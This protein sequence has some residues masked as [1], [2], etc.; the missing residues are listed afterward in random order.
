MDIQMTH[1]CLCMHMYVLRVYVCY[2]FHAKKSMEIQLFLYV[3]AYTCVCVFC[4]YVC[5]SCTFK[6][7][8]GYTAHPCMCVYAVDPLLCMHEYCHVHMQL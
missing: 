1:I 4:V 7:V 5:V 6:E 2:G 8:H 3:C